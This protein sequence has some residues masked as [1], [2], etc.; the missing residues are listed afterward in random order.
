MPK[1]I[2]TQAAATEFDG[3]A[4]RGQD[5]SM[6]RGHRHA[7]E[8]AT[9]SWSLGPTDRVLDVGCGNGWAL[10]WMR[11]RGAGSGVGFDAS[12][13]MI[14]VARERS[15]GD[16]GLR[17]AVAA[18]DALPLEDGAV[19]HVLSV[20]ALY[21]VPDPAASLAEWARVT[22][23]GGRLSIMIDL[24][25]ENPV[26]EIWRELLPIGVHLLGEARW[27]ALLEAA[28]WTGVA[29]QRVRSADPPTPQAAFEPDPWEPTYAA[30][31]GWHEA[32][33]LVLE[34]RRG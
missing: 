6:E 31:L 24:Y 11:E 9:R 1:P 25:A 30:H 5:R 29:R 16:P 22:R 26:G 20:E 13:E 17:F 7:T 18:A 27:C 34:A 4:R 33:S 23:S 32:G 28:G 2:S 8:A 14:R 10:R 15:V 12:A 3:W 19:S 21:Y